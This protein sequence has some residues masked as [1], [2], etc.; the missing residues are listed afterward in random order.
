MNRCDSKYV[1][2]RVTDDERASYDNKLMKTGAGG[3]QLLFWIIK[4]IKL[5]ERPPHKDVCELRNQIGHIQSNCFSLWAGEGIP[6]QQRK[7]YYRRYRYLETFLS[8][9]RGIVYRGKIFRGKKDDAD[10]K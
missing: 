1:S 9:L 10:E 6:A 2:L 8:D 5:R 7:R 3:K 4:G